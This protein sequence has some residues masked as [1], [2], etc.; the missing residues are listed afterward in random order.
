MQTRTKQRLSAFA[1]LAA[2]AAVPAGLNA[3]EPSPTCS[4]E[5]DPAQVSPGES[6]VQVSITMS[7][8]IGP[9]TGLEVG[10]GS[11]ITLSSLRDLPRTDL[12]AGDPPRR[13][14][15]MGEAPNQ[16]SVWLNLSEAEAGTHEVTFQS[17]EGQCT[18]SIT[19][20]SGG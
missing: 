2:L 6:A 19:V 13:P 18:A 7:M 15:R 17:A 3:Q 10:E 14:I 9:V 1:F 4:A 11:G 20:A 8:P 16:W 5:I 12:A